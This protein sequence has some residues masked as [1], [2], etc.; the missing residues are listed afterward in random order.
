MYKQYL[1]PENYK[2]FAI[3]MQKIGSDT[4]TYQVYTP[5][6]T[7]IISSVDTGTKADVLFGIKREINEY[8]TGKPSPVKPHGPKWL[9]KSAYSVSLKPGQQTATKEQLKIMNRESAAFAKREKA[10]RK[11]HP[12]Y[13]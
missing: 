4:I 13:L 6:G 1:Q 10:W 9:Y 2:G 12:G 11:K 5:K 3:E 8:I 7:R